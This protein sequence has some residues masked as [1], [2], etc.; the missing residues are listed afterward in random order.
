MFRHASAERRACISSLS[1]PEGTR[2]SPCCGDRR[3]RTAAAAPASCGSAKVLEGTEVLKTVTG[4]LALW[5]V[6][7][8]SLAFRALTVFIS[9]SIA[10][11][12]AL[13]GASDVGR[14]PRRPP[15]ASLRADHPSACR[16][17]AG[18]EGATG[19]CREGGCSDLPASKAARA[20]SEKADTF[21]EPQASRLDPFPTDATGDVTGDLAAPLGALSFDWAAELY[22]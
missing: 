19:I 22:R 2:R 17:A 20:D 14:S 7:S 6:S 10:L 18:T 1:R 9:S 11:D 4:S 12:A 8:I 15:L 5:V 3:G 13:A 16:L 21:S